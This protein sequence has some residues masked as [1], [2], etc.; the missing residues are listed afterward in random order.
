MPSTEHE[1]LGAYLL[2]KMVSRWNWYPKFEFKKL[3]GATTPAVVSFVDTWD[4][5][6]MMLDHVS[7]LEPFVTFN[8]AGY[9]HG[10]DANSNHKTPDG[11][12]R[13][14][15]EAHEVKNAT[16]VRVTGW[17]WQ[18]FRELR[19]DRADFFFC[20]PPYFGANPQAYDCANFDHKG[21]IE[22]L[23][24]A[25]FRWMLTEY[26]QPFYIR[27]F[28]QPSWTKEVHVT[29]AGKKRWKATE[30]VWKNY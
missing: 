30:C 23:K 20:D 6:D 9:D 25:P 1:R 4:E 12:E 3:D 14:S 22:W 26:R 21:L 10:A 15:R 11:M 27:A 28:G 17:D 16:N 5:T 18:R 24:R 2:G 7:A 29:M 13:T 19:F 8:G